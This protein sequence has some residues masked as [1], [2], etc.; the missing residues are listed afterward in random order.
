MARVLLGINGCFSGSGGK[1]LAAK[2]L[3]VAK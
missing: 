3:G 1:N 2:P